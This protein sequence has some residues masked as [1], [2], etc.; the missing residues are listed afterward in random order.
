MRIRWYAPTSIPGVVFEAVKMKYRKASM[1]VSKYERQTRPLSIPGTI[2]HEHASSRLP[3]SFSLEG[4][5]SMNVCM[6]VCMSRPFVFFRRRKHVHLLLSECMGRASRERIGQ[7][8]H[9]HKPHTCCLA[10]NGQAPFT[11]ATIYFPLRAWRH[12]PDCS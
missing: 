12:W 2:I 10:T 1:G 7:K 8:Q 6:S 11:N 5:S 3:W 4:I 9:I